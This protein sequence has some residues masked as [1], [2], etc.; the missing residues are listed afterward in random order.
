MTMRVSGLSSGIDYESWIKDL[1][2][3]ERVP[4][5]EETQK[6]T[7]LQWKKDDYSTLYTS[8]K[9]FTE[10]TAFNFKLDSSLLL[11]QVTAT[12][13]SVL[14]ATA[15]ADAGNMSHTVAVYQLA[16]GVKLTSTAA[17]GSNSDKTSLAT[18]FGLT[19]DVDITINGQRIT[20]S[21]DKSIYELVSAINNSGA[22]VKATYDATL[23]RFFLASKDTGSAASISFYGSASGA[24]GMDFITN[25]LK[26]KNTAVDTNGITSVVRLGLTNTPAN[27]RLSDLGVTGSFNLKINNGGTSATVAVNSSM[28]L[29]DL[30]DNINSAAGVNALAAYDSA[31]D[32][33][34][35]KASS[36]TLD[37]SGS[38]NAALSFMSNTLNLD[39]PSQGKDAI[40]NIDG[41]NILESTNSF[42]VSG[43]SY[44]LKSTGITNVVVSND[45]DAEV[46][47]VQSFVDSYNKILATVNGKLDEKYDRDY[48]PLTDDQKSSMKDTDITNWQA[49]ARTGIF[50]NDSILTDMVD[51]MRDDF[52]SPVAG[53]TGKY[54]SA[55]SIGINT[56]SWEEEG[57]IYVD[58]TKLRKALQEDPDILSKLF[59]T[60]GSDDSHS[61]IAQRLYGHLEGTLTQIDNEAGCAAGTAD[62]KS[63]LA[64]QIKDYTTKITDMNTRAKDT[65]DRYYSEFTAME[66]A[67]NQL[68][69]QS[70]WLS[71]SLGTGSNS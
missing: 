49:K 8:I 45:I 28:T 31:N 50:R 39:L 9:D 15:N 47:A 46:K 27:T 63:D 57:K 34:V 59:G 43:T 60:S 36:G 71:N 16:D 18:Q 41:A 69:Q 26:L 11:K 70:S 12:D 22:N 54:N 10:N 61:G 2:K 48:M 42:T 38:D 25:N 37:F 21:K 44:T 1:M 29:Q 68:S 7:L 14:S 67:L 53:V 35:L 65:E 24:G 13:S 6:K 62:T 19:S 17:L 5:D 30:L 32:K 23:D 64:K 4:I 33:I 52:S 55:A 3:A 66:T 40:V 56:N 51:K 20:M 58:E